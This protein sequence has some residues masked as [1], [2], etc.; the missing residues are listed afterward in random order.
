M[1]R[2]GSLQ[3]IDSHVHIDAKR[4]A[5]E[6]GVAS[7][8]KSAI[9]VGVERFVA[10]AIHFDSWRALREIQKNY[11]NVFP[12]AGVHP[13]D[14]SAER[15]LTLSQDL[16]LALSEVAIPIVGETGL[17]G[18]YDF[19]P[20]EVQLES[21]RIHLEVARTHRIPVI[22]HCRNT[23]ELLLKELQK[24][25]TQ[26]GV[27]HCFTGS[28]EWAQRFLDLGLHIG[29]TGIV[30]FKN[31]AQVQEVAS[32]IP[33][34]RL[35]VETDGP[36]LAPIPFRGQTNKPEYIPH[37]VR[38]IAELREVSE[39]VVAEFTVRNTED[40]FRLPKHVKKLSV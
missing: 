12:A 11:P 4:Y 3:M 29:I 27:V 35:L 23:E 19:V 15:T 30:T 31:S 20:E 26:L 7:I 33:Q 8:I 32:K 40:L 1:N 14:A 16:E 39:S 18:H 37:I 5:E 13:H 17:E 10:P 25:G 22:L 36:Y 34:D 2:I 24:A 9:D 38:K 21:L 6:E 28:W